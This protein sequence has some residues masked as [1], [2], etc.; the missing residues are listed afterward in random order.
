[1]DQLER[2]WRRVGVQRLDRRSFT[3][4]EG[5]HTSVSALEAAGPKTK[6]QQQQQQKKK[7]RTRHAGKPL[8]A[9]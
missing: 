3:E 7:R 2:N 9:R 4:E 6:Q 1:M 8:H 5:E